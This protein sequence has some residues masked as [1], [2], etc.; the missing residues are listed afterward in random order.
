[1][2]WEKDIVTIGEKEFVF[3][4]L[5]SK[6]TPILQARGLVKSRSSEI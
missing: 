6:L 4:P 5:L 2:I 3:A 1:L